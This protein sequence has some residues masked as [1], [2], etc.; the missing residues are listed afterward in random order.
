M[1]LSINL[2]DANKFEDLRDSNG[3][4]EKITE[5]VDGRWY[6]NTDDTSELIRLL[7]KNKIRFKIKI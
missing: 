5:W 6:I 2:F 7:N 3:Y 1:I 4:I